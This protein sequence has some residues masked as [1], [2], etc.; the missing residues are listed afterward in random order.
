[1]NIGRRRAGTRNTIMILREA[2]ELLDADVH[3]VHERQLEEVVMTARASDFM[4]EVL[5]EES[6][7]DIL[8]TGL[9]NAQVIRTASVFGIKAVIFV[10]GKKVNQQMIDLAHEEHVVLLTTDD[11][12]Y[13]SCGKLYMRGI[14][15]VKEKK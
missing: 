7:P 8:L 4:S 14:R 6:V 9:C 2:I 10:R 3:F 11:S 13:T 1:M 5:I 15:G 12:L